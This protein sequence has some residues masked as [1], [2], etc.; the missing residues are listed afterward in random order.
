VEITALITY[1]LRQSRQELFATKYI[2]KKS[3][4]CSAKQSLL[5]FLVKNVIF[6]EDEKGIYFYDK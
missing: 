6:N 5:I 4:T 1:F 3:L 2:I